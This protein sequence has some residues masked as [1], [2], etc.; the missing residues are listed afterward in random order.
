VSAVVP[1]GSFAVPP[2]AGAADAL[3]GGVISPGAPI[4]VTLISLPAEPA[5]PGV[6]PDGAAIVVEVPVVADG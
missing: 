6:A 2:S 5:G 1:D 3:V 4:G